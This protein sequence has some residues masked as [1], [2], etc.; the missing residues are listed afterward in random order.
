MTNSSLSRILAICNWNMELKIPK[1]DISRDLAIKALSR[2]NEKEEIAQ[3]KI[4]LLHHND[5]MTMR[6]KRSN[7]KKRALESD[8]SGKPLP[9]RSRKLNS[10]KTETPSPLQKIITTILGT[11]Q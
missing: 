9:K 10:N 11:K 7:Q 3:N 2:E 1:L 4:L 8:V 5:F 6:A